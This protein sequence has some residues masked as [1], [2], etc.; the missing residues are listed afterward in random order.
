MLLTEEEKNF[1][2]LTQI[3]LDVIPKYLRKLF[4]KLWNDKFHTTTWNSDSASGESLWS[5]I[6]VEIQNDKRRCPQ[7][8]QSKLLT[9]NEESWDATLLIF[10]LLHFKLNLIENCDPTSERIENIRVIRNTFFGHAAKLTLSD[11]DYLIISNELRYNALLV[12]EDDSIDEICTILAAEFE[13]QLAVILRER[14]SLEIERNNFFHKSLDGMAFCLLPVIT[15][16]N[17]F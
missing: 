11:A 12:F 6:P 5:A 7:D 10:L 14:L 16:L 4:I 15:I 8:V 9:G 17:N 2:K 13:T 3:I 1:M